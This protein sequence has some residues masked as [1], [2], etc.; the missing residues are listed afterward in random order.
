MFMRWVLLLTRGAVKYVADNWMKAKGKEEYD[1][2]L[3]SFDRHAIIWFMWRKFGINIEDPYNPTREPL[4]EDHAAAIYF[5]ING[6]EYMVEQGYPTEWRK[7]H[8]DVI[9]MKN[10]SYFAGME[11]GRRQSVTPA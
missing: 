6:A 1:R 10:S 9:V 4:T 3:E 8:E 5:N 2:F 7:I 11:E